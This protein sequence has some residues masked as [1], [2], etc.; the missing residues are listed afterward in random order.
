MRTIPRRVWI[1]GV[2]A[3]LIAFTAGAAAVGQP[4]RDVLV[5][6]GTGKVGARIVR[7]LVNNGDRVTVFARAKSEQVKASKQKH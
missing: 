3:W 2:A 6:G 1:T 5:L 4:S 7:L